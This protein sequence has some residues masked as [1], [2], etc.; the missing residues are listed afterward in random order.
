M[1]RILLAIILALS[2]VMLAHADEISSPGGGGG[3][4]TQSWRI[5]KTITNPTTGDTYIKE[6][7]PSASHV[8]GLYVECEGSSTPSIGINLGMCAA[9][10]NGG[11]CSSILSG[12]TAVTVTCGT[13]SITTSGFASSGAVTAGDWLNPYITAVSGVVTSVNITILGTTP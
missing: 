2:V 8:T 11:S 13:D 4:S 9:S 5:D 7:F 10:D 6:N 3:S 1:K 12:G